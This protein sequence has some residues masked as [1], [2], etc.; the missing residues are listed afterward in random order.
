MI[1]NTR[2]SHVT[3]L[4]LPLLLLGAAG[5]CGPRTAGSPSADLDLAWS[6]DAT[7]AYLIPVDI[8]NQQ[9]GQRLLEP[10]NRTRIRKFQL[11]GRASATTRR[12]AGTYILAEAGEGAPIWKEITVASPMDVQG[13]QKF[14]LP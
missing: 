6:E 1:T 12:T 2:F 7:A 9:G 14:T 13:R 3:C 4:L 11:T 5:G 8:W 10:V